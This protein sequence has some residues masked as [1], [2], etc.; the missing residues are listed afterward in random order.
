MRDVD[1]FQQALGLEWPW[2]VERSEFDAAQRR[3]DLYIDF[4][5]GGTFTCP[6]CGRTG[7]KAHD[8]TE[9]R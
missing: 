8:T 3:L 1:L 5:A 4:E 2:R 6:S 9:K 7:C